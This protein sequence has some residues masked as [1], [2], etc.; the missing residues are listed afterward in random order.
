MFELKKL[1]VEKYSVLGWS[2][3][4]GTSM[5][6]AAERPD[7]VVNLVTVGGKACYD[8]RMLK[9]FE[10]KLTILQFFMELLVG[11]AVIDAGI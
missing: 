10:S 9:V 5:F 11:S 3:G 6:L 8:E 7:N 2:Q 4:A 1:G